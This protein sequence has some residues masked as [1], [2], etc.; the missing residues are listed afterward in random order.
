MNTES[1]RFEIEK[2]LRKQKKKQRRISNLVGLH[3]ENAF[4]GLP[5]RED[6]VGDRGGGAAAE[7]R[8]VGGGGGGGKGEVGTAIV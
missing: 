4:G 1:T 3:A 6:G 7:G 8:R 2:K 5:L